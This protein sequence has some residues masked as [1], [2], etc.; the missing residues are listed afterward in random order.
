MDLPAGASD[1]E[2]RVRDAVIGAAF[3]LVLIY[4]GTLIP[5]RIL[6]WPAIGL[7]ILFVVVM[8]A[9]M[10]AAIWTNVSPQVRQLL[11]RA[12]G[13]VREDPHLGT[14]TRDVKGQYW[15]AT[16]K[17]HTLVVHVVIDGED[18]PSPVL[19][20]RGRDLLADF[21]TL[22]DRIGDFLASELREWKQHDAELAA[23]VGGLRLSGIVLRSA[24]GPDHVLLEFKGPDEDLYWS[25]EYVDGQL[26]DLQ[27]DS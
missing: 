18:E 11:A 20:A 23:E 9:F 15:S 16:W 7:G 26:S 19:L 6:G 2:P 3:G 13:H 10:L 22:A 25:C 12:R 5:Y 4:L 8:A 21:E 1:G 14:L 17:Y 27:Y 24:D